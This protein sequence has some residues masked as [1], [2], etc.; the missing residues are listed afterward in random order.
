MQSN[1]ISC[2][3]RLPELGEI[4]FLHE[5]DRATWVGS[6]DMAEEGWLWSNSYGSFWFNK[7]LNKWEADTEQD[8]D[9]KPTHWT[10]L[11]IPPQ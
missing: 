5:K 2:D 11:P 10:P 8:D 9:Y 4:V 1:W 7:T 3:D 6:R